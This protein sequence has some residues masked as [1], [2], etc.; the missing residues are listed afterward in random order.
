MLVGVEHHLIE[1]N[2]AGPKSDPEIGPKTLPL[3]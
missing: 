1:R 2:T 3:S